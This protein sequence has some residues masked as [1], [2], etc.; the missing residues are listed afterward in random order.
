MGMSTTE[1]KIE[2]MFKLADVNGDHLLDW[3]EFHHFF[4]ALGAMD[5]L[6]AEDADEVRHMVPVARQKRTPSSTIRFLRRF[7]VRYLGGLAKRVKVVAMSPSRGLFAAVDREDHV[8]H[9]YDLTTGSEVRR[10]SGH[11]DSMLAIVFSPD[12]KLVATASRDAMLCVWDCT[13]GHEVCSTRH[14]GVVTAVEFSFDGKYVYTGCQDNFVRKLTASKAKFVRV[15]VRL[16]QTQMGV[17]V[18]LGVQKRSDQRIVITR[19][20]DKCA[21]VLD[22][23]HLRVQSTLHGHSGMVWHCSFNSD[24]TRILTQCDKMIKLWDAQSSVCVLTVESGSLP[25]PHKPVGRRPRVWTTASFCPPAFN[26]LIVAGANDT[27]VYFMRADTG[28]VVAT[29]DAKSSVYAVGV[30]IDTSNVICGDDVGNMFE[31]SLF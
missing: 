6:K 9:I 30:G 23:S 22:S 20:C 18:S 25:G 2:T 31:I 1:E 7:S 29:I 28:A 24:D 26:G 13:V 27:G 10:L 16:P 12:R 5:A 21:H 11:T 4:R 17:I 14:P 19:S 8:A 3:G 15:M